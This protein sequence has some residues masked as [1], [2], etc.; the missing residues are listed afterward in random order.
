MIV[1][2]RTAA[3]FP[4]APLRPTRPRRTPVFRLAW[5]LARPGAQSP[6]TLILPAVAFAVTTA[7]ILIVIGGV[8]MF[9]RVDDQNDMIYRL[10]SGLALALLIV[11]LFSLGAAAARLSARRSDDR[12]A[13]LRLL[14]ATGRDVIAVTIIESTAV[15]LVGAIAGA[16]LSLALLPLVGLIHFLGGPIGAGALLLG[17]GTVAA[18]VLG[19]TVLAGASAAVGLRRVVI[20]P[21]GV[22]TRQ[23]RPQP[24]WLRA[25][26]GA[27]SLLLIFTV[28][29]AFGALAQFEAVLLGVFILAFALGLGVLSLVGPWVLSVWARVRLRRAKTVPRLL[30]ARGVLDNPGAAWRQVGGVA[31]TSFVAVVAGTGVAL[32]GMAG[33]SDPES[34]QLFADMYTGIVVTLIGSFLMVAASVGVN[35][36]ASVLD[37]RELSVSLDRL[38]M[39][40]EMIEAARMTQ[41]VAP[42]GMVAVG[43]ALAGAL[44][45]FPLTGLALLLNPLTLLVVGGSLAGGIG[46]VWLSVRATRPVLTRVLNEPERV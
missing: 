23:R 41:A 25:V 28:L 1:A 33:E 17:P 39:S 29:S 42:V 20:S 4:A 43:S 26:I 44:V 19:I 27:A 15:A 11:P 45:V 32:M 9:F 13:S 34:A 14:G 16:L 10:L 3:V 12:L 30:A 6:A 8:S 35:Q 21:L 46:L 36:A 37:R 2:E 22:R 24:H 18:V 40:R 5:M 31:M 38:G 7:L